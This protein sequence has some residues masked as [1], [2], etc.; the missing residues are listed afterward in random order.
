MIIKHPEGPPPRRRENR[1][2]PTQRMRWKFDT[3]FGREIYSRRMGTI[4]PVRRVSIAAASPG[5]CV[6][7]VTY[8]RADQDRNAALPRGRFH[9]SGF[10]GINHPFSNVRRQIGL[11]P[12]GF[13]QG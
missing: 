6:V 1:D 4:E 2:G 7:S 11:A 10:G 12:G 5:N 3:P 9:I 8:V 13:D